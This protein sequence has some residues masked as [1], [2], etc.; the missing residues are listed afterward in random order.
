MGICRDPIGKFLV[1]Q[2]FF[3]ATATK[4]DDLFHVVGR[5]VAAPDIAV[6][7]VFPVIRADRIFR[8]KTSNPPVLKPLCCVQ[9]ERLTDC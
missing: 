5:D 6:I 3:V 2:A 9:Q 4:T 7:I 1:L 8:H